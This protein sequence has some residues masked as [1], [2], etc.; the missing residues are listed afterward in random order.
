MRQSECGVSCKIQHYANISPFHRARPT[1]C[2]SS[3]GGK[4]IEESTQHLSVV[5]YT[6]GK[7]L[8]HIIEPKE[9]TNT[10]NDLLPLD[11]FSH[12]SQSLIPVECKRA[13][14]LM[15]RKKGKG[16]ERKTGNRGVKRI[17]EEKPV[18][19]DELGVFTHSVS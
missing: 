8:P 3:I 6:E 10:I 11:P 16:K 5:R 2:L 9:Y 13:V 18:N 1:T 14:V 7:E 17:G 4:I 19:K 12:H 15:Q